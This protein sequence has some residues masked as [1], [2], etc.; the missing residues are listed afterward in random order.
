[1]QF[2]CLFSPSDAAMIE[3][4]KSGR[5]LTT[6]VVKITFADGSFMVGNAYV[7]AAGV[8]TGT[9]QGAV[10]TNASL[11]FQGLPTVYES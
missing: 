11:E 5:T 9:A 3:L 2:Q 4:G 10:Q 7:S 8:P 6:R 1:M